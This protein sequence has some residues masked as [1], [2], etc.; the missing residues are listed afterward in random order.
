MN[1]KSI[2]LRGGAVVTADVTRS[3]MCKYCGKTIIWAVTSRAAKLPIEKIDTEY[4][5]HFTTCKPR[6]RQSDMLDDVIRQSE[7]D[8]W[9]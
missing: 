3:S 5:A 2:T 4:Q 1:Y 9:R 8:G 6:S 7:R